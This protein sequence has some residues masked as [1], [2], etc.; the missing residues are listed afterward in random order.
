MIR[1]LFTKKEEQEL[2][3]EV[4]FLTGLNMKDIELVSV[5]ET[6]ISYSYYE[7]NYDRVISN[8]SYGRIDRKEYK[9][10]KDIASY[11]GNEDVLNAICQFKNCMSAEIDKRGR[12]WVNDNSLGFEEAKY[13]WDRM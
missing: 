1:V 2:K 8:K 12:I 11:V 10:R 4:K 6:F 5:G 13:I 7:T 3:R 9:V